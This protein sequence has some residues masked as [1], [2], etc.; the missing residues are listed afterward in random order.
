MNNDKQIKTFKLCIKEVLYQDFAI[1]ASTEDEAVDK[2]K[3][4]Y[5]NGEV[6]VSCPDACGYTV[7]LNEQDDELCEVACF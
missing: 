3:E 6:A 1:E 5:N 7:I 2:L 4:M